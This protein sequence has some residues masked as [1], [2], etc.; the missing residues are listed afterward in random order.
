MQ[1]LSSLAE[2]AICRRLLMVMFQWRRS[3]VDFWQ[4]CGIRLT[5]ISLKLSLL[6][7]EDIE[8]ICFVHVILQCC[9]SVCDKIRN[10]SVSCFSRH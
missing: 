1:V 10:R 3:F 4:A 9:A 5:I 7:E 8:S 6:L 2:T